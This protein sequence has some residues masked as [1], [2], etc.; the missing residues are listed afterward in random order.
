MKGMNKK[1]RGRSFAGVIN[2]LLDHD[3]PEIVAGTIDTR[4]A[5]SM[6]HELSAVA[7]M[8]SDIEKPVWHDSLSLPDGEYLAN[9]Q[10][11][12]I[13]HDY[14]QRMGFKDGSQYASIKHNKP[15]QQHL[16]IFANRVHPDGSIYYGRNENLKS[17]RVIQQLE[18][19]Y[20]LT[21]TKGP[22]L[23]D[24]KIKQPP[25]S[26]PRKK[27]MEKSLRTGEAPERQILQHLVTDAMKG[28]PTVREFVE[29]LN[30]AGVDAIPNI[31]TT[32]RMN[33]FSFAIS[34]RELTFS[35]SKLGADYKWSSLVKNGLDYSSDRDTEF[36]QELKHEQQ[37]RQSERDER[38]AGEAAARAHQDSDRSG[39]ANRGHEQEPDSVNRPSD[40]RIQQGEQVNGKSPEFDL[41]TEPERQQINRSNRRSDRDSTS[42]DR[43]GIQGAE[44]E[45]HADNSTRPGA[46]VRSD[47]GGISDL[48][49]TADTGRAGRSD[50][51]QQP[52]RRGQEA[53]AG[54]S[55]LAQLKS[56]AVRMRD[57][58][59]PVIS[60]GVNWKDRTTKA[61]V[62]QLNQMR[63][64]TYE[65]GMFDRQ[66]K[67][68]MNREMTA[69][70]AIKAIP[71]MKQMNA[72]GNDIYIRPGKD[73]NSGLVLIDDVDKATVD[74]MIQDG[75][76]PA[77]VVETSP[78][79][80]QAWVRIGAE[81][82]DETR[83]EASRALASE[84][85]ADTG[86]VDARHYGRLAGFT[87][88]KDEHQD[89]YGRR[90]YCL[91]SREMFTNSSALNVSKKL[92]DDAV[93]AKS[94]VAASERA[95]EAERRREFIKTPAKAMLSFEVRKLPDDEYYRYKYQQ[96]ERVFGDKFDPSAADYRIARQML[97]DG[98]KDRD[99]IKTII[100]ENSPDILSRKSDHVDEYVDRTVNKAANQLAL[101]RSESAKDDPDL[102]IDDPR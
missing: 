75:R 69:E 32:G 61:V 47:R 60:K 26:S 37:I 39:G 40:E 1:S 73:E 41:K 16:H 50:V 34:D 90:P 17:T 5:N 93:K 21:I 58:A 57:L 99:E 12:E 8:R 66:K 76:Q 18:K 49:A 13:T 31:A 78:K 62:D 14:M 74:Q 64:K 80:V 3:D 23:E 4:S 20:G 59:A 2:Y 6:I 84:Y 97:Q 81:I 43:Q 27:E 85:E 65:I 77:L 94:R 96:L 24:E 87:N 71:K 83:L 22:D 51:V 89:D 54:S 33:G 88:Q 28:K 10:W 63:C 11:E 30:D 79:N 56:I 46:S 86:S 45:N 36:L 101:E 55:G 95:Q 29:R 68:M 82:D 48:P 7:G 67:K 53:S 72:R 44:H 91:L 35:G 42:E 102:E 25:K 52:E 98:D 100:K 38:I 70:Q 19:D 92:A 9:D 15:H